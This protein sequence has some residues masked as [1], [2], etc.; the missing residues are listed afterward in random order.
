MVKTLI[1]E[2]LNNFLDAIGVLKHHQRIADE[3]TKKMLQHL[4]EQN[5]ILSGLKDDGVK[6]FGYSVNI[7]SFY[8][9]YTGVIVPFKSKKTSIEESV[10]LIHFHK[11][12]QYQWLLVDAF[13]IFEDFIISIY[14]LIRELYPEFIVTK[15]KK[16]NGN[17]QTRNLKRISIDVINSFR[18]NLNEL[19]DMEISN[20]IDTNLRLHLNMIEKFRHIIVHKN[21]KTTNI[22]LIIIDILKKSC[23]FSD[24]SKEPEARLTIKSYFGSDDLEGLLIL[25][26]KPIFDSSGLSIHINRQENLIN[27][28]LSYALV[29]SKSLIDYCDKK[30][31]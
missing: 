9:P 11:N 8:S 31:A 30:S 24:K 7:F 20:K 14:E 23:L 6:N 18:L 25:V 21:G 27:V 3:I 19:R 17:M 2:K 12:K 22:E 28:L 16:D 10:K 4:Y 13:E 5:K 29:L 1:E 26:E 15:D